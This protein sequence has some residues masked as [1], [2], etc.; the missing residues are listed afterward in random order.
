MTKILAFNEEAR[1]GLEAGVNKLAD[2][3]K[4]TLGPRGRN[5]VLD[6]KFGAPTITNDGVSIAR[7]V[8]LEDVFENMG[9][10][11]VKEVA[12]KTN[13]I[14]GDGTTTA[15]VLAQA[16]VREGLRNV[17][18][19]ANPIGLKRG[20]E[21]A[22]RAAV[23]T[24]AD[25]AVR[26]D[27]SK[28]QIA[29]VAAISAADTEIGGI[30]ADAIDRVGKDGV[31]TV[32]ESNT[33]GMDLDF[34]EGMQ[35]DK[36]YLSP[37]FVTDPERQEAVLEEPYILLNQGKISSVQDMLP[38]L[39]K[40]MQ[41]GRPLLIIAEDV[42]GE[43]LATLVVNRI[44]GTF[45]SVALKAP[46]FGERRKAMLQDMATLTGGQVIAEEVG[47]KLDGITLDMLGSAR[48]VV[49]T[50]DDTTI[51]EGAGDSA[52]VE[53][54]INQ[55]KAEIDNTDSD[56]DR[57]K[58]QERLAKLAGG[59]ALV[60]V[61]AATEVELK[62]KKHRIEDALSATRAAIEEGVVAGG[63]TA[64]LRA[65]TAV[66]EVGESLS[67]DEATGAR[68]VHSALEA[69]TRLIADNAGLEGAVMVREVE[70]SSGN[71][72]LNAV[73][74]ELEDLVEAGVIDPAMVTRAALQNAASIAALLLTTEALVADK[75]EPAPAMPAGGMDPMGGMGGMGGMM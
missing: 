8:E 35:F 26:V 46:G 49:V 47:L 42:E 12:T 23:D 34:V 73:T 10:Q 31:V 16:L 51:V 50:K 1:R 19:G 54:R 63:G 45:S 38:V 75:P 55:I 70:K 28:D 44:R 58:L 27:D 25:Q 71:V 60:Q 64:L 74:G 62:E 13:D 33:F 17:A 7:E 6:K 30:I 36:G 29:N 65:R 53:G 18:A 56:W 66:A 32:E 9:A 68:I 67:G 37:Y 15:T 41:S 4:V 59:V 24:I 52:D 48:K 57:E 72:G 20:I 39:E 11:L 22:V 21:Q 3:V 69:P 43:A 14:A 2:A 40:V 61:G 5:V